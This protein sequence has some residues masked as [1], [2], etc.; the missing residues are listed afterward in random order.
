[1]LGETFRGE[2][3]GETQ[4]FMEHISH[5]PAI[6]YFQLVNP[7]W[8][9]HGQFLYNAE[10]GVNT[11]NVFNEGWMTITFK[12]GEVFQMKYPEATLKG[13]VAGKRTYSLIGTCVVLNEAKGLKGLVK[14]GGEKKKGL[15][16]LFSSTKSDTLSG[17]IYRYKKEVHEKTV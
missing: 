4:I 11:F 2:L 17:G 7:Q 1:L 3:D 6:S 14:V 9:L 13:M 15:S 12:D 16:S 10:I 5:H 8:E